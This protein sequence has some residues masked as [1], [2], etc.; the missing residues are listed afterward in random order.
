M[1]TAAYIHA[2][3]DF[4]S[5]L[6]RLHLLETRYDEG[7][8]RR[9]AASGPLDG[10]R[11]LEV[12]AGAGSV[13]RWLAA[14]VGEQGHVVATDL[15]PRFLTGLEGP[16][17]EVRR[18]DVLVDDLEDSAYDLV[19]CRALLLHLA[20]PQRALTR[21][22]AAL[23]PGGLLLV[24]D[25]DFVSMVATDPAHRLSAAFDR[26]NRTILAWLEAE[27][28]LEPWFGRR[29]PGMV[30]RIGVVDAGYEAT[31]AIRRGG[32]PE[33]TL[34]RDS[35]H[36][37]REAMRAANLLP[38]RDF[39]VLDEATADPSFTF[40]DAVSVGAWGRRPLHVRKEE[41]CGSE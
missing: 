3:A 36:R 25:A 19:H 14:R 35:I 30:T 11:C 9:I 29:L 17:L 20:D 24:E 40:F 22:F 16:H 28:R 26:T 2:G 38:E 23:R 4:D 27:H 34:Y 18:H 8:I 6:R 1:S 33:A 21:M 5:E 32:S 39:D 7:T 31:V 13:A 37:G 10:A 15:D 41:R 12:G